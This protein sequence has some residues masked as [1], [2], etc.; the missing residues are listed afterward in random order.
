MVRRASIILRGGAVF[1]SRVSP[2]YLT[3]RH[4]RRRRAKFSLTR[5]V[6]DF[7][8]SKVPPTIRESL[9][10][11]TRP[12]MIQPLSQPRSSISISRNGCRYPRYV[13][14]QRRLR[15]LASTTIVR[16]SFIS[17]ADIRLNSRQRQ[18]LRVYSM[19]HDR[20]RR[21]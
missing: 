17:I 2:F 21:P 13:H 16:F 19:I 4:R 20:C 7:T 15:S 18:R 9:K 1:C 8:R 6:W 14:S 10:I 11:T 12:P 3:F 5:R